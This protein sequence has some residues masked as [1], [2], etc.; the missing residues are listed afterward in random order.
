MEKS[1]MISFIHNT[2]NQWM[3]NKEL[4]KWVENN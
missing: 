2:N 1:M 4:K 3:T